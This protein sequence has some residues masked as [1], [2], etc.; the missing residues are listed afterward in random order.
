VLLIHRSILIVWGGFTIIR[1]RRNLSSNKPITPWSS[2]NL[3]DC[4]IRH[5]I[6]GCLFV[7]LPLFRELVI[8]MF[9]AYATSLNRLL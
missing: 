5:F 1:F 6:R 7:L 3:K 4:I 2:F 8:L 9:V